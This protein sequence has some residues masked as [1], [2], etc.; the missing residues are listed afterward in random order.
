MT[1]RQGQT[2]SGQPARS[3]EDELKRKRRKSWRMGERSGEKD[4]DGSSNH[5]QTKESGIFGE[6]NAGEDELSGDEGLGVGPGDEGVD[7][8]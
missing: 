7:R 4:E 1:G 3:E 6:S 8:D 5:P 2:W